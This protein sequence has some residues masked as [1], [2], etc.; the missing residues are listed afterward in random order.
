MLRTG[1]PIG[2]SDRAGRLSRA[3]PATDI[4]GPLVDDI[5]NAAT[6]LERRW[7]KA[8]ANQLGVAGSSNWLKH[9][10]LKDRVPAKTAL[11]HA[12]S[13]PDHD[14]AGF[15]DLTGRVIK[16]GRGAGAGS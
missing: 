10:F 9:V 5:E 11:T 7:D 14:S 6:A 1:W 3:Q 15:Q 12:P 16:E 2:Q 8:F 13:L 4:A